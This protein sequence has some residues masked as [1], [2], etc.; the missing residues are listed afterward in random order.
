MSTGLPRALD[1]G[2]NSLGAHITS[3]HLVQSR[4]EDLIIGGLDDGGIAL[5]HFRLVRHYDISRV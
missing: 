3:L 1:P 4:G 2:G 5:W